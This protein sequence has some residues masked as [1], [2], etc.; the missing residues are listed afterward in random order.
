[1]TDFLI[2]V[3]IKNVQQPELPRVRARIGLLAGVVG[4]C[5]NALLCT[6]KIGVGLVAGSVSIMADG[7][8]NLSD[9]AANIITLIGFKMTEKPADSEHPFGHARSE[10]VSGFVVSVFILL[11]GFELMKSSVTKILQPAPITFESLQIYLLIFSVLLKIWMSGFNNKL[12]NTIQST[13]LKAT[14]KDSMYDAVTTAIVL[15]GALA[16]HYTGFFVDGYMGFAVS[17]II[18]YAGYNTAKETLSPIIG[19]A[20]SDET[21]SLIMQV[22]QQEPLI[23]GV[24]DLLVHD[25]GPG[26]CFASL[27][28]EIPEKE[29]VMK[30]HEVIDGIEKYILEQ[31]QIHLVIH[32]DPILTDDP[33]TN[34][35]HEMVKEKLL[36]IDETLSLHDLRAVK[37]ETQIKITFDVEKPFGYEVPEEELVAQIT[38]K[39]RAVSKNYMPVITV[40]SVHRE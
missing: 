17:L 4:I 37:E 32:Y 21:I 10:Y 25:Y 23:V 1:M 30:A 22:V 33:L 2:K 11:I 38:E 39:I 3:F 28:V 14:A 12:G 35:M 5:C 34:K 7:M 40:D 16:E 15:A 6:L 8:N 13:A 36:E 27:H 26:K 18:L 24:H 20:P 19:Q 9:A 31:Y 29:D